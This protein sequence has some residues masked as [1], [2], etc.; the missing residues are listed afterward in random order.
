MKPFIAQWLGE[1]RPKQY[2]TFV[3]DRSMLEH[4][5]ERALR[6]VDS[7]RIVTVI[8]R[9]H[10]RYLDEPRRLLLPGRII[11]QPQNRETAPG[12]FLPLAYVLAADPEAFVAILPSDHFIRPKEK[13]HA[14]MEH[15]FSTARRLNDKIVLLGGTA[16]RAECDYGWIE[17][18]APASAARAVVSFQEK[19]GPGAA[20]LFLR[21]GLLWNT[22]IMT[23]KARA[24]WE[25]GRR[26][27]P[28]M[29]RNFDALLAAIRAGNEAPLLQAIYQD[30]ETINFSRDLLQREPGCAVVL[31]M[32]GVQWC[33]WGRPE[34]VLETIE[35][36]GKAPCFAAIGAPLHLA[37]A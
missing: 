30:M 33:D 18:G 14:Q 28:T 10:W 2:C 20:K 16:E 34:R 12:I 15:A 4:T 8:G 26:L 3:G 11:E 22:M 21:R 35:L 6:L 36:M 31:A 32:S 17:A 19:P 37:S 1:P 5:A 13:F 23:A 27:C 25:L 29:M 9:G 7:E 24:L